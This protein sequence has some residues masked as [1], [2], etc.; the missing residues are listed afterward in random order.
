LDAF[1][2]LFLSPVSLLLQHQ[3]QI[4]IKWP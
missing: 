2:S 4:Q 1:C 3:I